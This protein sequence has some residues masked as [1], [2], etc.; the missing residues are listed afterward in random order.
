MKV[1]GIWV[2]FLFLFGTGVLVLLSFSVNE[3]TAFSQDSDR[4]TAASRQMSKGNVYDPSNERR[5]NVVLEDYHPIDPAPSSKASIK[6]GPIEHGTPF[7]P[8]I[9]GP[10]P[11]GNP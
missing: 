6:P 9:P 3:D 5:S 7:L 1:F 8:Y 10:P 4:V 2:F 11:L